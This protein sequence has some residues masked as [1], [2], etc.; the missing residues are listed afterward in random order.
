MTKQQIQIT[1]WW[2]DEL[3]CLP[4]I[5]S[6]TKWCHSFAALKL[7]YI[8]LQLSLLLNSICEKWQWFVPYF[9]CTF[10]QNPANKTNVCHCIGKQVITRKHPYEA[11]G[12]LPDRK[13]TKLRTPL[14]PLWH[15]RT[16]MGVFFLKAHTGDSQHL[17][18]KRVCYHSWRKPILFIRNS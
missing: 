4:E 12:G 11:Q 13:V 14:N 10:Q 17:A 1:I 7:K 8:T 18:K 15:L 6:D 3:A 5:I 2:W 16:L 9:A